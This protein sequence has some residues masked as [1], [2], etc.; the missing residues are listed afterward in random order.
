MGKKKNALTMISTKT[1]NPYLF[2]L[3]SFSAFSPVNIEN[4]RKNPNWPE[5]VGPTFLCNGP[6]VLE[7]W[8]P[9]NQ[10]IAAYNPNYRETEDLHPEKII[11]NIV[12]NDAVTLEMFEK[13]LVDVI[14]DALTD[15]PIES[16]PSLEKKWTI[17][18]EPNNCTVLISIN[19][20]R[21]PFNHPKIRTAF[22]IAINRQEL[23]GLYGKNVKKNI[24]T[25]CINLAYQAACS[26]TNLVLPCLKEN[27]YSSFFQDNDEAQARILLEEGLNELGITK[28]AF[29][30]VVLYYSNYPAE[31]SALVQVIQQ[32]WLKALGILI[33]L[34]CLDFKIM[35]DRLFNKDYSL[36]FLCR[37]AVYP[38]PMSILEKYKYKEYPMN[39]SNWEHPEF[40]RLLDRSYYEQGDQRLLTLEEAERLLLSEMPVIPLYHQDYVYMINPRLSFGIPVWWGDRML[41]P[42]S[43]KACRIQKENKK[44]Y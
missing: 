43:S 20:D 9:G 15:I 34:E 38:D 44:A 7:K 19:T 32:Q 24:T 41:L 3:L 33:K 11:F 29:D 27:R 37:Q 4:D 16:I 42:M 40:I 13:G 5:K 26:A 39:F 25:E 18:C 28:E 23:I 36:S 30:S 14:G 21:P 31:R 6:Y 8:E 1:P 2:K 12:E 35:L 22:S 17:S 10:I